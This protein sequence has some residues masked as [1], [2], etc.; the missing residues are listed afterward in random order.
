MEEKKEFRNLLTQLQSAVAK[1]YKDLTP[2]LIILELVYNRE[3]E[4]SANLND[5]VTKYQSDINFS[6]PWIQEALSWL[7]VFIKS[8]EGTI[9]SLSDNFVK[10]YHFVFWKWQTLYLVTY[11][12]AIS[13]DR[14]KFQKF[15]AELEL[16]ASRENLSL[17]K[18]VILNLKGIFFRQ[19]GQFDQSVTYFHEAIA[20][21][22]ITAN[23][24][25]KRRLNNNLGL[26]YRDL[27]DFKL[28]EKYIRKS[29]IGPN[30]WVNLGLALYMKGDLAL[31]YEAYSNAEELLKKE[32]PIRTTGYLKLGLGLHKASQGLILESLPLF[33]QSLDLFAEFNDLH[34]QMLLYGNVARVLYDNREFE[35]AEINFNK[36][37]ELLK[38]TQS[39]Q[40]YF[41]YFCLY[42]LCLLDQKKKKAETA[43]QYI[44][45]LQ[46]IAAEHP[47]N[48][49]CS[50][51]FHY[52][53][54]IHEYDK[55]NFSI[56]E[57]QFNKV[58]NETKEKGPFEL[59][60]R[61]LI[62]Q[63]ELNLQKF[64]LFSDEEALEKV[65]QYLT[66]ADLIGTE[67]PIFPISIYI[68]LYQAMIHVQNAQYEFVDSYITDAQKFIQ[69]SGQLALNKRF[70]AIIAHIE[71][72]KNIRGGD[73]AR[74]LINI[75][76]AGTGR[77]LIGRNFSSEEI[78][79]ILWKLEEE[80]PEVIAMSVPSFWKSFLIPKLMGAL[81]IS[82]LG[83]G[84]FYHEG[85]YGPLPAPV[86]NNQLLCHIATK[87]VKD[88]NQ[89][90]ERLEG[91]NYSLI[92]ILY[93]ANL[94]MDRVLL[95]E[96]I[97]DWWTTITDLAEF[98]TLMIDSLKNII[99]EKVPIGN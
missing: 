44:E 71:S 94:E 66:Q 70:K 63:A 99:I 42:V 9:K 31:S 62:A 11:Q 45:D 46:L 81:F 88:S 47:Q 87:L 72:E 58:I 79:L 53:L 24:G 37:L 73:F 90:D 65:Q 55:L 60:L 48:R 89:S 83:Q 33:N 59:T 25:L 14:E 75:I 27:G 69:K 85:V 40:L 43:R 21:A 32:R 52:V 23:N 64:I 8:R 16:L 6:H 13:I 86:H 91:K 18:S 15:I 56:A 76:R 57:R 68:K 98:N 4:D 35:M 22:K 3:N 12:A 19:R 61:S 38:Q 84:D 67:H 20:E 5:Q 78:G 34:G 10:E 41:M 49:L 17:F 36:F 97:A 28:A 95:Q 39:Y 54:A 51:W 7:N 93:P 80:G 26:I 29:I 74:G 1:N 92:A 77:R 82:V 96:N 30:G 50:V 2:F